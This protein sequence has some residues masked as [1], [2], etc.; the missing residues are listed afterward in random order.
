VDWR[1]FLAAF[2]HNYADYMYED[3]PVLHERLVPAG[4]AF[5][6]AVEVALFSDEHGIL[7]AFQT[8]RRPGPYLLAIVLVGSGLTLALRS[9]RS[10][11]SVR[12]VTALGPR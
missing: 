6:T 12:A 9:V 3:W 7:G 2:Q 10:D 1:K 8:L 4:E 5:V 11:G